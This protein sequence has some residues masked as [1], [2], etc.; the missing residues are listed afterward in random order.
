[1]IEIWRM[2][3]IAAAVTLR[4]LGFSSDEANRL[5]ALKLRCERG[6]L[7]DPT[8]TQKQLLF[9]RWLV[10]TGRLSEGTLDCRDDRETRGA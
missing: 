9:A 7:D 8:D 10:Q 1:M 3:P 4:G 5:V 2:S 6:D